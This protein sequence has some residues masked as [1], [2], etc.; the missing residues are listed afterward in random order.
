MKMHGPGWSEQMRRQWR[1][2]HPIRR[3]R[4]RWKC[5]DVRVVGVGTRP[6]LLRSIADAP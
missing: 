5:P 1:K 4:I 2:V 3:A 6:G